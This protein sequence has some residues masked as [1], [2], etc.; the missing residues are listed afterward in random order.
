LP[1]YLEAM[2]QAVQSQS[3][4]LKVVVELFRIVSEHPFRAQPAP[5]ERV[6]RQLQIAAPFATGGLLAFSV[7]EYLTPL[8]GP[9][10]EKLFKAYLDYRRPRP[11]TRMETV[12]QPSGSGK[13]WQD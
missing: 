1:V 9:E 13:L 11:K 6:A 12:R 3:R 5:W 4:E 2:R 10:A 8:G 7:P